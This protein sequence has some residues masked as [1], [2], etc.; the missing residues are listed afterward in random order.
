MNFRM[1]ADM[2]IMSRK[3]FESSWQRISLFV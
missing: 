2:V 1:I 3:T